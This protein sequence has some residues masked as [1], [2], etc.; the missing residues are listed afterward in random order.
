MSAVGIVVCLG[1]LALC[2]CSRGLP[3]GQVDGT[4]RLDGAPI[5][6]AMVT[7]IPADRKL[8]Q[9]TGF[10]DSDGHFQLRC[11][12]GTIGAAVGEHRVIVI[13]G[14]RAPSGKGRDDDELPEGKHVPVSR[15]P[16]KYARPDKTPL[17]Q[18]VEKG[19]QEVAIEIETNRK[20]T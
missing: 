14:A 11:S 16:L 6:D 4:V 10:T 5:A 8:P 15:V 12:N 3:M 2:G 13:D 1:A 19:P 9:S 20:P 18:S 17:R 7:F